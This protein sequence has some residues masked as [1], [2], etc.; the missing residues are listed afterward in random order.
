MNAKKWLA[1]TA[2]RWFFLAN[3]VGVVAGLGAIVFYLMS[4]ELYLYLMGEVAGYH[5]VLP[6]GESGDLK[7]VF[8]YSRATIDPLWALVLPAAGG[9][10]AG[11]LITRFAPEAKGHGTDAAIDAYHQ[12]R[13]VIRTVVIWVKTVA[14]ALTLGTG[15]SGGREG[16][17]AQIGA[18]FGSWLA[19]RLGLSARDRRILLAAGMGAG[20]AAIFRAP[21]AGA[22]FAAEILYLRA[23]FEGDV[24]M[25]AIIS[26]VI[27]YT[28]FTI[29]FGQ[30]T[31]FA[32]DLVGN[33]ELMTFKSPLE[34][35]TYGIM[36]LALAGL[37]HVY[38]KVFYGIEDF[39]ERLKA[40]PWI[41]P[42]IGGL[43]T[44]GLAL[45]LYLLFDDGRVLNVLGFGYGAL[46]EAFDYQTVTK[47]A[48]TV[49]P[50]GLIGMFAVISLGKLL[51]TSFT[52]SSGGS[53]GVFGPSMVIGG[54]AGT[55]FGLFFHHLWPEAAPHPGAFT[56]V[57]MA[58]FFTG[59]A[60]V[61]ISTLIMVS[62]VTGNYHLLLPAMW[63]EAI[64]F[65][66]CR[67]VTIY[68]AQV[69]SLI[70]SPAHR[71]DFIIDILENLRVRD[72][73]DRLRRPTLV[74]SDLTLR[75]VIKIMEET[76][77]HYFIVVGDDGRMVGIFST[78]D[79]RR[80][81][82]DESV[83]DLLLASD[84]M[85]RKV[86]FATPTSDLNTVLRR[87]TEKNI[88]ELP[89]VDDEDHGK[90]LGMLRRREVIALYNRRMA[91]IAQERSAEAE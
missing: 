58:G 48:H 29:P 53:A 81:L 71:G 38:V 12:K 83:W 25:P 32:T 41:K 21:L 11:I 66:L 39:F 18:G 30:G 75:E 69:P 84:I 14:S 60:H 85:T 2:L 56:I 24:I 26:S 57:A 46:Q 7:S 15:G 9:L 51:T 52:I 36:A 88:D 19:T 73:M 79:L 62:E 77:S 72:V 63:V 23:D 86:L 34:L 67:K 61:P 37:V 3:I 33:S 1:Q 82:H 80:Y 89:I 22:L 49:V 64:T 70:D 43:I 16:P 44:G 40:R 31:L 13:G 5:P 90:V 47:A 55:A 68:R 74:P 17:I 45:G 6:R 8:D 42:M 50:W 65:A 91:E 10:L 78:N 4:H 27:S 54:C 20:I 76:T 87:F 35:I 28:V 59:A